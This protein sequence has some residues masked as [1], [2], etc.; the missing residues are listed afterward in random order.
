MKYI[1][2][3]PLLCLLNLLSPWL[4]VQNRNLG[5]KWFW[6][7]L[8]FSLASVFPWVFISRAS[9]D[10]TFDALLYD[11]VVM[12]FY[13]IGI[14]YFTD[15]LLKISNWQIIGF[16]LVIVGMFLFKKGA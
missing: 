6:I 13:Y 10:L 8:V 11:I 3:V 5:G 9:K 7:Y 2:W 16:I 12:L 14:L 4:T 15:C 1:L